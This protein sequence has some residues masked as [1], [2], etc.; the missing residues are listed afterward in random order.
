M[1]CQ[2]YCGHGSI[3]RSGFLKFVK[4]PQNST[5]AE[6]TSSTFIHVFAGWT[7]K[8]Q[9]VYGDI[10]CTLAPSLPFPLYNAHA[11]V[12]SSIQILKLYNYYISIYI[13]SCIVVFKVHLYHTFYLLQTPTFDHLFNTIIWQSIYFGLTL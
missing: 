9:V 13:H 12:T 5:T 3:L 11:R 6:V 2:Y 4:G 1:H 10:C 7:L 8:C